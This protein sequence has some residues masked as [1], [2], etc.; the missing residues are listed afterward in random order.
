[1]TS[2]DIDKCPSCCV[3]YRYHMGMVET[4]RKLETLRK[5]VDVFWRTFDLTPLQ[6]DKINEMLKESEP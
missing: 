5:R 6:R 2:D 1:M 4:C 3:P